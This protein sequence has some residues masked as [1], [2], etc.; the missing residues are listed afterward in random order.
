MAQIHFLS[1]SAAHGLLCRLPMC[2]A[3]VHRP[4]HCDGI[5]QTLLQAVRQS[6][7]TKTG[8]RS[9]DHAALAGQNHTTPTC[10]MTNA[11]CTCSVTL[12]IA[13]RTS[14]ARH[15]EQ[16]H[17]HCEQSILS[18]CVRGL[19]RPSRQSADVTIVCHFA[20]SALRSTAMHVQHIPWLQ[21]NHSQLGD[22]QAYSGFTVSVSTS[23]AIWLSLTKDSASSGFVSQA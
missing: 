17:S 14:A 3:A 8:V 11:P 15:S 10:T 6:G 1:L 4:S 2:H 5:E 7:I 16:H 21:S 20:P 9:R 12:S 18:A 23:L 22:A 13:K 19:A